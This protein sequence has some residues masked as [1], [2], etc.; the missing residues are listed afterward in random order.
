MRCLLTAARRA[1]FQAYRNSTP[2][3]GGRGLYKRLFLFECPSGRKSRKPA[4]TEA[5]F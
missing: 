1:L 4:E 2:N 5:G 3:R